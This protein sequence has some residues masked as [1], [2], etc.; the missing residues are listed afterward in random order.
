MQLTFPLAE[1]YKRGGYQVKQIVKFASN[2]DYSDVVV[3]NENRKKARC[4][5][6]PLPPPSPGQPSAYSPAKQLQAEDWGTRTPRRVWP[7]KGKG[8]RALGFRA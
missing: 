2:R 5:E 3:L 8:G 1:Y 4:A 6:L 7:A